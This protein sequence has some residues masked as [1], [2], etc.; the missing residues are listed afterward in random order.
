MALREALNERREALGLSW[1]DIGA[2]LGVSA[3]TLS[4]LGTRGSA[5]GDGVLRA[6]AWLRRSPESF[7]PYHPSGLLGTL[8]GTGAATLRFDARTLYAAVEARV[9]RAG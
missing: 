6:V 5:E 4:G 3:S 9:P 2:E 7:V 8:F 1:T